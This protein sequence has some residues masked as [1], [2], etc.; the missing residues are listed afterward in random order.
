MGFNSGFKGLIHVLTKSSLEFLWHSCRRTETN[1]WLCK[2][3]HLSYLLLISG[4]YSCLLHSPSLAYFSLLL[5]F[6]FFE[7]WDPGG[8]DLGVSTYSRRLRQS[9]VFIFLG[10]IVTVVRVSLSPSLFC[11]LKTQKSVQRSPFYSTHK[12]ILV[13][14]FYFIFSFSLKEKRVV[15]K[16]EEC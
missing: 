15:L 8:N 4:E 7:T 11:S 1:C 12:R 2:A 14:R 5:F 10:A 16:K 6:L 13:V 9:A 3:L